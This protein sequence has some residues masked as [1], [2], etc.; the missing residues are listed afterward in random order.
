MKTIIYFIDGTELVI[1]MPFY[2]VYEELA[3]YVGFVRFGGKAI[4]INS[5]KYLE[6][7]N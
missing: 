5:I 2:A 1:D 6:E 4:L 7:I 3:T